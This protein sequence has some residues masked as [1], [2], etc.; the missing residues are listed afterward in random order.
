MY[1]QRTPARTM[2]ERP[3]MATID[4]YLAHLELERRVSPH[5]LD[6]YGRDLAVLAAFAD[7][8]GRDVDA[9]RR[10][11]LEGLV[12]D[13]MA[14]G[15]SPR[16]VGRL[17]AAVRGYYRFAAAAVPLAENP[18]ADLDAPRSLEALPK[19]LTVEEVDA[20]LAAPDVS[21]PRG[22]ARPGAAR[23]ALRHRAARLGAAG[24]ARPRTSTSTPAC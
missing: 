9:L 10:A 5:T 14:E 21:T 16:S 1:G 24:A 4:R 2:R 6:G 8:A 22:P 13:R 11:D 19:F 17:V 18:A 12:R 15:R 23:S 7:G 20:L 3:L